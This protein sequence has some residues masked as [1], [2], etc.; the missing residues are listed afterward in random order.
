MTKTKL[1]IVLAIIGL[2]ALYFYA[3]SRPPPGV[4]PK[5]AEEWLPWVSLATG[6]VS[7]L[8]GLVTLVL[9]ILELKGTAKGG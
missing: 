5:G 4:E 3:T 8:G 1:V 6:I 2:V 7:L 9:K